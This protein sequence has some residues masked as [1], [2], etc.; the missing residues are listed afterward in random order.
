[1][2]NGGDPSAVIGIRRS[3]VTQRA[4]LKR[5]ITINFRLIDTDSSPENVNSCKGTIRELL[6]K[7]SDIDSKINETYM[8]DE[9]DEE[10]SEE[11]AVELEAQSIYSADVKNK[12]AR[13]AVDKKPADEPSNCKLKLPDIRCETFTGEGESHLEYHSF[14]SQFN[15]VIGFRSGLSDSTKL[16]Y[17]TTYLKGYAHKLV[18]HLQVNDENYSVALNLL[19]AEFLNKDAIVDDLLKKLTELK[20]KFDSSLLETKIYIND[21]R[22]IVSDLK[23]YDYDFMKDKS[24][25]VLVS[26]LVFRKLPHSFQQELVRKI[27]HNYPSLAEIFD[28]YAEVVKTLN[29]KTG[30]QPEIVKSQNIPSKSV[31][32]SA[33]V[34]NSNKDRKEFKL[35]CKFCNAA[36]HNMLNCRKYVSHDDRR[37]RC[38]QLKLCYNCTSRHHKANSCKLPLDF[39]CSGCNSFNHVSPM[40]DKISPVSGNFCLN[41]S[42]DAGRTYLLPFVDIKISAGKFTTSVRCLVDS[43][44]QRSYVSPKVLGKLGL[45]N[46]NVSPLLINT[47]IDSACKPFGEVSVTATLGGRKIVLP[48]LV[49]E[50]FDLQ[51]KIDGLTEAFRNI[52]E[53]FKLASS[54]DSDDV[55]LDGLLGVDAIQWFSEF[56]LVDC[57]NGKAFKVQNGVIPT[58]NIDNFLTDAQM[59]Q[60]YENLKV[61]AELPV[62]V[63]SSVVNFVLSPEKCCYDPLAPVVNDSKI[64]SN[65]DRLFSAEDMGIPE[66]LCDFDNQMIKTFENNVKFTNGKYGVNLPWLDKIEEVKS[67]YEVSLAI[68]NRVIDKLKRDNLYDRYNEVFVKQLAEGIMEEIPI[69]ELSVANHIWIPHRPVVKEDSSTTKVRVVLNCSLKIGDTPSLNE[70]AY[71]GVNLINDLLQLLIKVRAQKYLVLSDI[72]SAYLMI[73]LNLESDM[74]KFSILWKDSNGNLKAY[75]YKT[76]VFGFVSSQ[77]ILHN[78]IKHHLKQFPTDHCNEILLNNMYVDNLYITGNDES[79]LRTLYEEC[80]D[81]MGQG[82]FELRSWC[83]NAEELNSQFVRDERATPQGSVSEKLL[84]YSYLPE[85]DRIMIS[86]PEST[87]VEKWTKRKILACVAGI[88]DPLGLVLPMTVRAKMLLRK[89]W[90]SKVQ[91]DDAIPTELLSEW[92]R[93]KSDLDK[94]SSLSFPRSVY[95]GKST[96]YVFCDASKE[97]YGFSCYLKSNDSTESN[98]IFSKAKTTPIK[99]KTIPTLELMAVHLALKCLPTVL[100][101]LRAYV[102]DVVISIDAQVVLSWVLTGNVKSKNTCARN[103]VKEISA[104]RH[105]IVENFGLKCTFKYVDTHSNP[106]DYVTRG[107]TLREFSNKKTIWL[108]GPEFIRSAVVQWPE[109]D[110][111]C[112]S[113]QSKILTFN[114]VCSDNEPI[115]PINRYSKLH[116]LLKVTA[117]VFKFVSKLKRE[118]KQMVEHMN[119]A[120]MYWINVEQ[121]KY[122]A[123]EIEF[124]SDKKENAVV[125]VLVNQLNLF[126]DNDGILRSRGRISECAQFSYNV[127]HPVVIPR[128]SVFTHLVVEDAHIQQK[129]LGVPSTLAAVRKQGWWVPK[130]RSTVRSVLSHCVVCKKL[131]AYSFRYP[132]PGPYIADKVNFVKPFESTGID[133]TG[134]LYTKIKG[135]LHKV[136]LLVFT[137]LSIRAIHIEVV[138]DMTCSNFL[139]AFIR[140]CN[141]HL[142]PNS[143]YSDNASTFLQAMGIVAESSE[144]DSFTEYLNKNNVRHLRIPLHAAWCG[145]AWERQMRT[146]KNSLH[147]A[148]GRRQLDYYELLTLVSEITNVINSRPLT[149]ASDEDILRCI[150]PNCFLKFETGRSLVLDGQ[151]GTEINIPRRSDLVKSLSRQ[152]DLFE[153]MR[154]RWYSEYLLSL[155]ENARDAY[156]EDWENVLK[157]DDVVLIEVPNKPRFTWQLGRVLEVLP[158]KDGIVRCAKVLRPDGSTGVH[159]VQFLY[160]LEIQVCPQV[161][162]SEAHNSENNIKKPAKREAAQ[163]CL[164]R[165]ARSN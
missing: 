147:K 28:N 158:G 42:S 115:I 22:C 98:L 136:Y 37:K 151:A 85:T 20:P 126:V 71:P 32:A 5:K 48:F 104:F 153:E 128:Q 62:N 64:E 146:I 39:A 69:G 61:K 123:K 155:R 25:N 7:I 113:E 73:N 117:Y 13:M 103:R 15:N 133:F 47:F 165:L 78:V 41:S 12:L 68:L 137:C 80:C 143:V 53:E 118:K 132:K 148:V 95:N 129:H 127:V 91:W 93:I 112:L 144:D 102:S 75:R 124:L 49:N 114:A 81:R 140:F 141:I 38:G 83:S 76:I 89:V 92:L 21:V 56:E 9:V 160:P 45:K 19:N 16:M 108:H 14:L 31:N 11:F 100:E 134:H 159:S 67:N 142:I 77:F 111:G 2:A 82:G 57:L 27:D 156:Q 33:V 149:Y 1:M 152:S 70:A 164:Q 54:V 99:T 66:Q 52:G 125:P 10:L 35:H 17:L 109:T 110:L 107:L 44:S 84:G 58:G 96:L 29:L 163:R 157:N 135:V 40:C 94:L 50:K 6:T 145:S 122:F 121:E 130:G 79:E 90:L 8:S 24:A 65:L 46:S 4:V 34:E 106:A 51:F 138:P 60:K 119:S 72:R 55:K 87:A 139:F 59:R 23:N 43:G 161:Q 36:G 131:N 26:H 162:S 63:D 86:R 74:N 30:R 116:K 88:F 101:P 154:D 150:T 18:Q 97:V 3:L 105:D 120:R